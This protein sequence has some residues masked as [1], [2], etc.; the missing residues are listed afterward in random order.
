MD[1]K[2]KRPGISFNAVPKKG[3]ASSNP[4]AL[5]RFKDTAQATAK[6]TP[7]PIREILERLFADWESL[8]EIEARLADLEAAG[9]MDE[10]NAL[11][12]GEAQILFLHL[13]EFGVYR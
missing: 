2:G 1:D 6:D 5:Q 11:L 12:E 3:K 9:A 13:E 10:H 7:E 8:N 4:D